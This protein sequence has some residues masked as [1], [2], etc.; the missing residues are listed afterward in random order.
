[1]ALEGKRQIERRVVIHTPIEAV[2]E[3]LSDARL[4]A[5]WVPAVDEVTSCSAEGEGVGATRSCRATLGRRKGTM[6]ERCVEYTP[7]SRIAY[8]VD[9]ESFGMR[10]MFD[11]YG[12]TLDLAQLGPNQTEV[13]LQTHYTPRNP[14]YAALNS[15]VMRR[16]FRKVC[17]GIVQGLKTFTESGATYPHPRPGK[18]SYK[19]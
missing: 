9:D 6:V 10:R 14:L 7:T 4:L 19:A 5:E 1:M 18:Q 15:L 16:Q 12:F 8:L 3:V 2:W 11:D 17:D 13:T